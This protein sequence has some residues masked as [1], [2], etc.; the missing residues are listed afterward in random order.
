MKARLLLATS[1]LAVGCVSP[2]K[3]WVLQITPVIGLDETANAAVG[4]TSPKVDLANPTSVEVHHKVTVKSVTVD[5]EDVLEISDMVST[6]PGFSYRGLKVGKATLTVV[7]S[8]DEETK[9]LTQELHVLMALRLGRSGHAAALMPSGEVMIIG[10]GTIVLGANGLVELFSPAE[11]KTVSTSTLHAARTEPAVARLPNGDVI[12]AGGGEG[13]DRYDTATRTWAYTEGVSISGDTATVLP[14]GLV[15]ITGAG[16][17]AAQLIDPATMTV[18]PTGPVV[19]RRS[20]PAATLLPDGEVLVAGG[21]SSTSEVFDPVSRTWS[22]RG[23]MSQP[24][25]DRSAVVL[26]SGKVLFAGGTSAELY[27]PVTG[28]FSTTAS[29]QQ[30]RLG[31]TLSLLPGGRAVLAGGFR[32][33]SQTGEYEMEMEAYDPATG[34]WAPFGTLV[35]GHGGHTATV[36]PDGRLMIAAGAGTTYVEIF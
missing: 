8:D 28:A 20:K 19:V 33:D 34:Q 24:R 27:D 13:I 22:P 12:V 14:S 23:V 4:S 35:R 3:Q 15:L 26:P 10:G 11:G 2:N 21:G 29:P 36:L 31:H 16:A 32:L 7:A 6:Q 1:V 9:T 18:A 25:T 17:G 30:P 5:P